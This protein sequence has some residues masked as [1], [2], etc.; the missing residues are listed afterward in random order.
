MSD[1][2]GIPPHLDVVPKVLDCV[3]GDAP[4]E[5]SVDL[6]E[7]GTFNASFV[8]LPVV[9]VRSLYLRLGS[10]EEEKEEEEEEEEDDRE[11]Q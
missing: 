3:V 9:V 6:P 2:L 4:F 7:Q 1:L 5:F 10:K 11:I 8:F